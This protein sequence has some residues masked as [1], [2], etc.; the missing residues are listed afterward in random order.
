MQVGDLLTTIGATLENFF[1]ELKKREQEIV[2][3][4]DKTNGHKLVARTDYINW[5]KKH[6]R[7]AA[8]LIKQQEIVQ[9]YHEALNFAN[10]LKEFMNNDEFGYLMENLNNRVIPGPQLLIKDHKKLQKD[11]HHP[12]RLVI[13]A[14]IVAATFSK[15][16]YMAIKKIFDNNGVRYAKYTIEEASDLKTKLEKLKLKQNEVTIMSLDIVN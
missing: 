9:L 3:P 7:D 2:V 13:P 16:G 4:T 15:I 10:S 12:T 5:V 6:M 8:I 11:G 14:T 1:A